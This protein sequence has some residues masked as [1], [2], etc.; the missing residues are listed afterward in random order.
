MIERI[1]E[2]EANWEDQV[3]AASGGTQH[4]RTGP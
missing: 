1:R 2:Q 3:T 4:E